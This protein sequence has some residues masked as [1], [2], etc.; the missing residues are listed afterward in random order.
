MKPTIEAICQKEKLAAESI[1]RLDGGQINHV[2]LIDEKYIVRASA[3]KNAYARLKQET[4]LLQS[5]ADDV[6][7]PKMLALGQYENHIYQIQKF[8][9]GKPLHRVWQGL[10]PD[11][12]D[13]ILGEFASYLKLLHERTF[14]Q[15]GYYCDNERT[16]SWLECCEREFYDAIEGIQ[17][18]N[19]DVP[20]IVLHKIVEYFEHHK[21]VLQAATPVLVHRDLWPGNI[22][23]EDGKITAILDFEFSMQAPRDYELLLIEQ[24]C[25]YPNDFVEEDNEIYTTADFADYVQLLKR[26]YRELFAVPNLRERLNLYHIIYSLSVYVAWYKEQPLTTERRLPIQP[27]AKAFNFLSEHG[28]RMIL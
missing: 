3:R 26:H 27:L 23:V 14:L 21:H 6:P 7:V 20:D 1:M 19:L 18:V 17:S 24:F 8:V 22:L 16:P 2:F 5:I 15:F 10:P 25:L 28:T 9:R 4:E 13:R 12:K 11:Q